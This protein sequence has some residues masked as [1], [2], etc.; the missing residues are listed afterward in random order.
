MKRNILQAI[1]IGSMLLFIVALSSCYG[2]KEVVSE[3]GK[4][5]YEIKDSSDPLDHLIFQIKQQT[6]VQVIYKFDALD[7]QWNLGQKRPY[8]SGGEYTPYEDLTPENRALILKTLS[9]VKKEFLDSYPIEFQK[10]YMALHIFLCDTVMV[11]GSAVA[12]AASARDHLA[13]NVL[14][15]DEYKI[16][17]RKKVPLNEEEYFDEMMA[18]LHMLLWKNIFTYRMTIPTSFLGLSAGKYKQNLGEQADP[19]YDIRMDGFW[20]YDWLNSFKYYKAVDET[21]DVSDY[22]QKMVSMPESKV[23]E[24]MGGYEVM[25]SKYLVL[26]NYIKEQTGIDLQEIGNKEQ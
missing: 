3:L 23:Y 19:N 14:G 13:I 24:A 15:V 6:G 12:P 16:V 11:K 7:A 17:K 25:K 20:T 9:R 26:R 2:E 21:T 18:K 8:G 1:Q 22:I 10:N 4:P 5:M